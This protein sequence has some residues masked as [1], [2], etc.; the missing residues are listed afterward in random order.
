MEEPTKEWRGIF[1]GTNLLCDDGN[2]LIV[3]GNYAS[4]SLL[5]DGD[6]LSVSYVDG[7]MIYKQVAL[8]KREMKDGHIEYDD[9]GLAKF[10]ANDG[11]KYNMVT[12]MQSYHETANKMKEGTE[13][14]AQCGGRYCAIISIRTR[15]KKGF[16]TF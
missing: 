12:S 16:F 15:E 14:T 10:C 7:R 2:T 8:A 13:A 6:E 3:N 1:D 4:K 5:V 11:T 9:S